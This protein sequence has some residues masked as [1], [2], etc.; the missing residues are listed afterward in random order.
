[1][2]LYYQDSL[3][4]IW[5]G[6]SRRLPN[7][8]DDSVDLVLTSPPYWNYGDFGHPD[9]IGFG[10]SYEEF[11]TDLQAILGECFRCLRPGQR[12]VTWVADL[13][14]NGRP[15]VALTADVH[16]ELQRVGFE[17][18]T[19]IIW[20]RPKQASAGEEAATLPPCEQFMG[21][22]P[23]HLIVYQKPGKPPQPSAEVAAASRIPAVFRSRLEDAVWLV[24]SDGSSPEKDNAGGGASEFDEEWSTPEWAVIRFWSAA[25]DLVLDPFAGTGL[26]C[27]AAKSLGRRTIGIELNKTTC[28]AAAERCRNA[29]PKRSES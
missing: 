11:N 17:F 3:A 7:L 12:I 13:F 14:G 25:G 16:K 18:E 15:R 9:Q 27:A 1:M 10:Q 2:E 8:E 21:G 26:F 22:G 29:T 20:H 24:P 23:Q 4:E 19:T 28:E 5:N 6:D